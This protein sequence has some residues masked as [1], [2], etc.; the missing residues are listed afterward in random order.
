MVSRTNS[1]P[2]KTFRDP[3][4]SLELRPDGVFRAIH[5]R[6]TAE[7]LEFLQSPLQV[8]LVAEGR[9]VASEILDSSP[10]ELL[11]RH[12]R[13]SFI[14]YPW[15]WPGALWLAAADLTL[16]L[17]Q[18]F[19]QAG[20][21]LKDATPLNVLFRGLNPVFVDVL[22]VERL[23]PKS[24]IWL[25]YGQFIRTFLLPLLAHA[26]LGWPLASAQLRRDGFE[27][28]EIFAALPWTRRLGSAALSNVTLPVI[29]GRWTADASKKL[30]ARADAI[31]R[32]Q[33]PEANRNILLKRLA[34]LRGAMRRV[35]PASHASTWSDYVATAG[36]YSGEEQAEKQRFV[37]ETLAAAA[38]RTVL[39]VGCNTGVF[40][41]IAAD[42]GAEVVAIDPDLQA[43]ERLC[44]RLKGTGKNILPLCV[45]LA[46]A[47]PSL[48]W[49]NRETLSFLARCENHFDAV[50]MLAVI[51][52]LLLSSQ[53]PLDHIASLASRIS[54]RSL[55][56]EW[57]PPS[58]PKFIEVLRGRE[59]IYTH[60]T[61][62]AMREA[63]L[64]HFSIEREQTLTNGRIL[65]HWTKRS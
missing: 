10:G 30:Q 53:I 1:V 37:R 63:F 54:R 57:V 19:I 15:E 26:E 16:D 18:R 42:T 12:P 8:E 64:K 52:H 14:S 44:A 33:G 56:L 17:C 6:N 40:S 5:E 58:D 4:G 35:T 11:L 60:I 25:P 46:Y 31:S 20:W 39:D 55:I 65:L 51:H 22:S 29:L 47:T 3:A 43:L 50:L 34:S 13:V 62:A 24:S 32:E 49:E 36:H 41:E 28:E 21:I 7:I 48:G 59:A 61:E 27:P 9:L 2:H 23:D 38:P 45:D